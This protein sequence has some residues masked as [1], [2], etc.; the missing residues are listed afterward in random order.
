MKMQKVKTFFDLCDKLG[1][2]I[3]DNIHVLDVSESS[4]GFDEDEKRWLEMPFSC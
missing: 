4:F 3:H 1:E 2:G